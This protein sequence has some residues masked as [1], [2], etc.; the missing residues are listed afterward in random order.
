MRL[1][2]NI[3]KEAFQATTPIK[4]KTVRNAPAKSTMFTAEE[5]LACDAKRSAEAAKAKKS[6]SKK[7]KIENPPAV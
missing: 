2:T 4:K 3:A 7:R 5:M 6:T 1:S